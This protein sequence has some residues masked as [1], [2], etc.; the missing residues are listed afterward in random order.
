MLK[1]KTEM[2]QG[3][4]RPLPR[5]RQRRASARRGR[6]HL[7]LQTAALGERRRLR[8]AMNILKLVSRDLKKMK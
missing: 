2:R 6:Q 4:E 8:I 3:Q 7:Q 5:R 1:P